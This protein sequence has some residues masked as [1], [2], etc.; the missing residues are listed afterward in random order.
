MLGIFVIC[1][2]IR[3]YGKAFDWYTR[4]AG[5]GNAAAMNYLGWMYKNGL[6]V[7]RDYG[8]AFK[9]FARGAEMGND[10]AA[11]ALKKLRG[12]SGK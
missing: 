3:D 6:G 5:N 8:K 9:W 4:G 1:F 2:V 10:E 11:E 7:P 12:G